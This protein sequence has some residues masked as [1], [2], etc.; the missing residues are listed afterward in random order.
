MFAGKVTKPGGPR[1]GRMGDRLV[2]RR[3][4]FVSS[5]CNTVPTAQGGTHE[6]GLRAA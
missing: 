1:H 6:Q 2:P 3:D 4:G 5:Y